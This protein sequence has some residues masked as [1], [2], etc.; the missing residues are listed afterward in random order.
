MNRRMAQEPKLEAL[1]HTFQGFFVGGDRRGRP[2]PSL[3]KFIS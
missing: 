2:D 1:D 3:L